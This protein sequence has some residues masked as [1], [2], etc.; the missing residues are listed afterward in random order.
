MR[1][2]AEA[3]AGGTRAAGKATSSLG[4]LAYS[5]CVW[6]TLST[7]HGD[8][9][10]EARRLANGYARLRMYDESFKALATLDPD[11]LTPN[12][13]AFVHWQRGANY[14]QLGE[15]DDAHRHLLLAIESGRLPLHLRAQVRSNLMLVD[16]ERGAFAEAAAHG[17]QSRADYFAA[18]CTNKDA[19]LIAKLDMQHAKYLSHTDR[20][21]ALHYA[22]SAVAEATAGTLDPA[23]REWLALLEAGPAPASIPP[24]RRP[25]L[26]DPP[27]PVSEAEAL[28]HVTWTATY[29]KLILP[30]PEVLRASTDPTDLSPYWVTVGQTVHRPPSIDAP[31]LRPPK[32]TVPLPAIDDAETP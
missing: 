7:S 10:L 18:K 26:E 6:R 23:D 16:F 29:R 25:W 30:P 21:K 27:A 1:A 12:A 11:A 3:A 15:L 8:A 17:E 2:E 22:R 14:Y 32:P 31:T 19:Q 24:L 9:G 4:A 28:R 13:Q 20:E 5:D